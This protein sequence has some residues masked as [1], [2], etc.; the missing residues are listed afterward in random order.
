MV[1]LFPIP[2]PHTIFSFHA[3]RPIAQSSKRSIPDPLV[4]FSEN[5]LADAIS[6]IINIVLNIITYR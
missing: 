6:A 3:A 2:A 5:I 4:I 1:L